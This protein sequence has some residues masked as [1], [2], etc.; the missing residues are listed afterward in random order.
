MRIHFRRLVGFVVVACLASPLHAADGKGPPNKK[1][2]NNRKES[3]QE[4]ARELA[5]KQREEAERLRKAAADL[6]KEEQAAFATA[7]Q[8]ITEAKNAHRESS[9]TLAD[10]KAKATQEVEKSLGIEK[11]LSDIKAAQKAFD[12]AAE[13]VLKSVRES[14]DYKTA[15]QKAAAAEAAIKAIKEDASLSE[16]DQRKRVMELFPRTLAAADIEKKALKDH[17]AAAAANAK[18]DAAQHRVAELRA[19]VDEKVEKDEVVR[20]ARQAV[21]K[22]SAAMDRAEAK[23]ATVKAKAAVAEKRL[24][25]GIVPRDKDDN[26]KKDKGSPKKD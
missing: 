25:A 9:K 19:K 7:N 18:L 21:E 10:A 14:A 4:K 26:D 13:P 15:K 3:P 16:A 11:A 23:L 8:E 1:N 17:P 2:N 6:A 20:S 5:Q 12:E 22:T 24:Q